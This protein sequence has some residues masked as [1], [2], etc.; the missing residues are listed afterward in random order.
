MCPNL[1]A[2]TGFPEGDSFSV[3]AM[4]TTSY[5]YYHKLLSP[6]VQPYSYADKNKAFSQLA[7]RMHLL[8]REDAASVPQESFLATRKAEARIQRAIANSNEM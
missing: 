2:I 1:D 5:C 7:K 4:L 3:V 8:T 6:R